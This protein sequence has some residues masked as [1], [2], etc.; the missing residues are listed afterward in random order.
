MSRTTDTAHAVI[1]LDLRSGAHTLASPG[2]LRAAVQ[3]QLRTEGLP[4]PGNG[5]YRFLLLDT[6]RG[7]MDHH[8]L[9]EMILGYGTKAWLLG[10]VVGDLPDAEDA[11]VAAR[12][13]PRGRSA[14]APDTPTRGRGPGPGWCSAPR[15]GA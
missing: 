2:A 14:A 11:L 3:E 6:P 1:V 7:L 4:E 12:D 8:S 5:H 9:Y 15:S 10:L 13:E